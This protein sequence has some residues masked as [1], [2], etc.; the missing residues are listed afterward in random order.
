M[1]EILFRGK[2]E[3]NGEWVYWN[4]YGEYTEPFLDNFSMH[5]HVNEIEVDP[6]TVGQ[7]TGLTDKNGKRIFEGDIVKYNT[8]YRFGDDESLENAEDIESEAGVVKFVSGAF[9]NL[10]YR[11]DT[12]DYWYSSGTFGHE[13]IGNRWDIPELLKGGEA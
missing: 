12:E 5:S 7:Y 6:A 1:R 10:P 9:T 4:V 11:K 13:V 3:D 8:A 2:R